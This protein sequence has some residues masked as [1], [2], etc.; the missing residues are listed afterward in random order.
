M[1]IRHILLAG[2]ISALF[3]PAVPAA[4]YKCRDSGGSLTYQEFPC[5]GADQTLKSDIASDYPAPNVVERE[6]LLLREQELYKRLE[7]QRD[8]L[9]AEAVAR[10]TR[11][12]PEPVPVS[13]PSVYWPAFGGALRWPNRP[14]QPRNAMRAWANG[15][16]R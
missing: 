16:L 14:H 1:K 2:T 15:Q 3:A 4:V 6:R 7:A 13:E 5:P 11:P 8:R 10:I 9:S 12:D